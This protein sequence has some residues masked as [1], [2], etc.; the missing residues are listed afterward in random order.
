MK[1]NL[2]YIA[3][4]ICIMGGV[5][6]FVLYLIHFNGGL[7]NTQEDWGVF[8]S[9]FN[10]I[11]AGINV[12]IFYSLTIKIERNANSRYVKDKI[13]SAQNG[14]TQIR[15]QKY[16]SVCSIIYQIRNNL[17]KSDLNV[18]DLNE[19]RYTLINEI[20]SSQFFVNDDG[21]SFLHF[22]IMNI[23]SLID[24]VQKSNNYNENQ[25]REL[26]EDFLKQTF[27]FIQMMEFYIIGQQVRDNDTVS[28]MDKIGSGQID[29]SI[30]FINKLSYKINEMIKDSN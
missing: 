5:V 21:E 3:L 8:S 11:I 1:K 4:L 22:Q 14:I 24:K 16:S 27:N 28:Y 13:Y 23:C 30:S 19:L 20:D 29:S 9:I 7:S 15:F 17:F 10:I 18:N 26:K 2:I 6:Q 25:V 12:C